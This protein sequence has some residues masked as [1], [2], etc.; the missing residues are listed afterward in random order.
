MGA[1]A[2][3]PASCRPTTRVAAFFAS[4]LGR[5]NTKKKSML[6]QYIGFLP[7]TSDIGAKN[8]GLV[9]WCV[10]RKTIPVGTGILM[11]TRYQNQ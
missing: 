8:N 9:T 3:K 10:I 6:M 4:A 11:L 2:A 5:V 7:T 1:E